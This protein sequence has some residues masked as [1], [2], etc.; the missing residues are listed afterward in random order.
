MEYE[1]I[2]HV[3]INHDN[4]LVDLTITTPVHAGHS[5]LVSNTTEVIHTNQ[6]HPFLTTEHGFLPV[7]QITVGM[8][9]L[10][11]DGRYGVIT[12]WTVVPGVMVMYNLEVAQDHTFTVGV[13]QWVVHN[14]GSSNTVSYLDQR[15]VQRWANVGDAS[16]DLKRQ[17]APD[18]NRIEQGLTYSQ[19]PHD[20]SIFAN[21][22]GILPTQSYG[23]YREWVVPE[24][25][26]PGPGSQRIITGG[27]LSNGRYEE[28]YYTAWH[29]ML[30]FFKLY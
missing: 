3:W 17:L 21:R 22:E 14:C 20:G 5:T 23:Y 15:G 9:V 25:G 13:G 12:G 18:I 26:I 1:P 29:Y 11:A 27:D 28:M 16:S 30:S 4:D 24:P 6:K 7:G 10:R 19:Y 8:H 2:L